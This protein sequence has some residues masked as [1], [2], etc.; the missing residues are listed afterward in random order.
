MSNYETMEATIEILFSEI[1]EDLAE[2]IN[3]GAAHNCHAQ[4][5]L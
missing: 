2:T 3:G 4:L 1:S 5:V